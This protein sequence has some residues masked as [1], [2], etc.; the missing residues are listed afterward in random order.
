MTTDTKNVMQTG[1]ASRNV[2]P[3]VGVPMQGYKLRHATAINDPIL[4]SALAVG[5]DRVEW[6]LLSIDAIGLDRGFTSRIRQT[7]GECFQLAPPA[8][9][10][11]WPHTHSGPAAL[12]HL[13]A[14]PADSSYLAFLAAQLAVLAEDAVKNLQPARWQI[15]VT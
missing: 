10:I 9:T 5:G 14:I 1:A 6:L 11:A 15:G 4:G 12:P 2:T 13:G 7:I 8:I 3:P